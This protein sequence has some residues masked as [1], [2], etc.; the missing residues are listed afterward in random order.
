MQ[1]K[2]RA[3]IK[4][5]DIVPAKKKFQPSNQETQMNILRELE[6]F[7]E[8]KNE[9]P[10]HPTHDPSYTRFS[11]IPSDDGTRESLLK[12][13]KKMPP[14]RKY[15]I[16]ALGVIIV[17]FGYV[18]SLRLPSMDM[19]IS[20]KKD[21]FPYQGSVLVKTAIGKQNPSEGEIPGE[22]IPKKIN[23]V[24]TF[25]PTGQ[26]NIK[27]KATGKIIIYNTYS[28]ASQTLVA[29]TRFQTS[30]GKIYRLVNR[31]IVP[32]TQT[33]GENIEPGSVEADIVADQAGPEYN[34]SS[35][36]RLTIPGF[37][38]S[39][40]FEKFYGQIAEPV[41]GGSDGLSLYPTDED[42]TKAKEQARGQFREDLRSLLMLQLPKNMTYVK[43]SEE[44][45][46]LSEK[47]DVSLTED[48]KFSVILEGEM[49][50]FVFEEEEIHTL[51]RALALQVLATE[52]TSE[53]KDF[54]LT[55]GTP[56]AEYA[57]GIMTLPIEVKAD[58]WK[59]PDVD[60]LKKEI[61]GKKELDIKEIILKK[62]GVEAISLSV[63]PFWVTHA[64]K[65]MERI[66]INL[67]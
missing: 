34:V 58:Y 50:L 12:E 39:E 28:S 55:Y 36:D 33:S 66:T 67:E 51:I 10:E 21:T 47:V 23:K 6:T 38:G 13:K 2:K 53:E 8:P 48:K 14:K 62:P 19:T 32:G 64:P 25:V 42:I 44:F 54:S 60:A 16:I 37:E 18:M 63:W 65:N 7:H 17:L 1:K 31:T 40:K 9:Q 30:D 15:A 41:Q 43:D 24:F 20:M 46:I 3:T 61:A 29:T 49:K 59:K 45:N 27:Q 11:D 26:K 52:E 57:S 35:V 5:V 22:I 4:V 56:N